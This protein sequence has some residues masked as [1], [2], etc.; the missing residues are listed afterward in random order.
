MRKIL[1]SLLLSCMG[2]YAMGQNAV[3]GGNLIRVNPSQV[4]GFKPQLRSTE[5]THWYNNISEA[6]STG[7]ENYLL[8]NNSVF[9]DSTVQVLYGDGAGGVKLGY[10]FTQGVGEVFDPKSNIYDTFLSRFNPYRV[11]SIGLPYLYNYVKEKDTL[12][13][14]SAAHDTLVFQFYT[15]NSGGL[16]KGTFPASGTF[17]QENN[18]VI[19]YDYKKNKGTLSIGEY[20]YILGAKDSQTT[21][22]NFL[23]IPA[24][25]QNGNVGI[26]VTK[27]DLFAYTV[28][29]RPGFKYKFGDTID[30][31]PKVIPP[32]KNLHSHFKILIGNT[33]S[34]ESNS[35]YEMSQTIIS[36]TRTNTWPASNGWN[37]AYIPG[38]AWN[39]YNQILWSLFYVTTPNLGIESAGDIKGY[40]LSNVYPNPSHGSAKLEFTIAKPEN[41]TVTVYDMLG[42]QVATIAN[43]AYTSGTHTVNFSTANFKT[44]LYLY[45]INAGSYTKTMKFTVT[46]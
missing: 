38:S 42:H 16:V 22:K 3:P 40:G 34:K 29:Y 32:A 10:C 20:K 4:Q 19:R 43:G 5:F 12:S 30:E 35:D 21:V 15:G 26:P 6:K 33:G 37:G 46:E 24:T 17:P 18:A 25:L 13:P 36:K 1:L 41:V 23:S 7:F 39:D 27:N 28:S 45:S 44:G 14:D 8:Y 9:G 11:D 2:V 31:S